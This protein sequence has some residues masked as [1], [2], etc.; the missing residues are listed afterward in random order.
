MAIEGHALD[1]L[2][3]TIE[4]APPLSTRTTF[5]RPGASRLS[6]A[7]FAMLAATSGATAVLVLHHVIKQGYPGA[8]LS[9]VA[10][11]GQVVAP[12][13]AVSLARTAL[14]RLDD[15]NRTGNYAVFRDAAAPAF[16]SINT[17]TG[18]GGIFA[19]LREQRISLAGAA[20]LEPGDMSRPDMEPG[21]ILHLRG[22]LPA[23]AEAVSF[24]LLFQKMSGEWR[25]F[26][27]AVY[28]ETT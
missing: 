9:A 12:A 8:E 21:G 19:W 6:F 7:T 15:A 10:G 25:L 2:E 14:L 27:I 1:S 28:R 11:P 5:L 20:L 3:L 22:T 26:G 16:Q 4:R 17:A 13:I 24:D 18:L 23:E